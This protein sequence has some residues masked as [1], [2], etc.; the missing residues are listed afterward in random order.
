MEYAGYLF[1]A[2]G[3]LWAAIFGYV[4][5]LWRR[6][7]GLQRDIASLEETLQQKSWNSR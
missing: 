6:Q 1:A 7:R 5:V 4:L 3:I 2:F